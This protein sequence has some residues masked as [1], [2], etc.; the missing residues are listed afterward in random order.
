[1]EV[2]W[3]E[4]W[5]EVWTPFISAKRSTRRLN[6]PNRSIRSVPLSVFALMLVLVTIIVESL[7]NLP[8]YQ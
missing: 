6:F 3:R 1:M 2:V 4:V 8:K 7:I 5:K